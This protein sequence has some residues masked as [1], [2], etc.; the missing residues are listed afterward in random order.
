M[1][2]YFKSA[3]FKCG[4]GDVVFYDKTLSKRVP[5]VCPRCKLDRIAKREVVRRE[6]LKAAT[7]E[8]SGRDLDRYAVRTHKEVGAILGVSAETVRKA[9]RSALAKLRRAISA[10]NL[11]VAL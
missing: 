4:C 8:I 7:A 3:N 11:K 6:K 10:M 9:E 1:I 2:P 5:K